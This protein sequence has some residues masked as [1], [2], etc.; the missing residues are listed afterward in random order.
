MKKLFT[1]LALVAITLTSQA[2]DTNLFQYSGKDLFLDSSNFFVL[3][4]PPSTNFLTISNRAYIQ[5]GNAV[6]VNVSDAEWKLMTNYYSPDVET[7]DLIFYG[8]IDPKDRKK[9]P[10]W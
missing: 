9:T 5:I 1:L 6:I 8:A 4:N 3:S 7:N 10:R 2:T